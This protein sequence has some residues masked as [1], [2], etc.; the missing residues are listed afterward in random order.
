[1]FLVRNWSSVCLTQGSQ[2][3]VPPGTGGLGS[4]GTYSCRDTEHQAGLARGFP[5]EREPAMS[6]RLE[7]TDR[8]GPS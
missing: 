7:E 1:M 4:E 6:G 3:G 2:Q 8:A 5:G